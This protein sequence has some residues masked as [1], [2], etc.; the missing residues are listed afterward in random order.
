MSLTNHA[1]SNIAYIHDSNK[2]ETDYPISNSP[3]L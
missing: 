3:V 1:L 2:V